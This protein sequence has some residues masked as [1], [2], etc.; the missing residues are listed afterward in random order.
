[1]VRKLYKPYARPLARVATGLPI[2]WEPIVATVRHTDSVRN[3]VWSP[4]SRFIA[5]G[6]FSRT[7]VLDGVTLERLHTFALPWMAGT[8][9][10]SFSPDS[11]SLTSFDHNTL[12]TWDLQTGGRISTIPSKPNTPSRCFSSTY[13]MDGR[14]VAVAYRDSKD[15]TLTGISTYNLLSGTRVYSHRVS[16]GRI[17]ASIWTHGELLRFATVKP[18]SINIWEV[19]FTSK[20]TLVEIE[21]LPAPDDIDSGEFLFLST[22][23][24]L[25]FTLREAVLVWDARNSK[26]L[27]NFSGSD[28]PRE[29]SFSS[30]GRFFVCG[31]TGRDIH[32]WKE[33][34]SP[35]GYLLHRKLVFNGPA[36][37]G[38]TPLLSP[39]GGSIIAPK[40]FE[41]QLWHT[42][43]PISP[44][45]G[46]PTQSSE[47][48]HFVLAFSPDKSFVAAGRFGDN[49][50]TILDLESGDARLIVDTDT[51]IWGLGMT[52]ST[53]IVV[54]EGK[55]ITWNLPAG[56]CVLGSKANIHDSVRTVALKSPAPLPKELRS[57]SISVDFDFLAIERKVSEGMDVYDMSTGEYLGAFNDHWRTIKDVMTQYG[58]KYSGVPLNRHF[59]PPWG[60]THRAFTYDGW[61]VDS[62]MKRVLWLPH[63]WRLSP[64]YQKSYGSFLALLDGV[65]PEPVIIESDS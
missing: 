62:R 65:L 9:W 53:A 33:S 49:R 6:M 58:I 39:D 38:T 37:H 61:M 5:V 56:H 43:D 48:T 30:D 51:E 41:T 42:T 46:V 14:I 27:L 45:S 54:G 2:L 40:Y 16:E 44:P 4:C 59:R 50:A 28:Q 63:H 3:A 21:S 7:E 32:L 52:G 22:L 36:I 15:T 23:S 12:I 17:A 11:R 10:L 13:S 20:H 25:A 55:I 64:S 47:K 1:M 26:F 34:E 57:A 29:F 19:G 31:T 8:R 24:R 18:G 60:R 35:T